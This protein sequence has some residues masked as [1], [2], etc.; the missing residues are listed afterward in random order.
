MSKQER[1]LTCRYW[2]EGPGGALILEFWAV[3]PPSTKRRAQRRVDGVVIEGGPHRKIAGR[4]D[5]ARIDLAGQDL[6]VIQTKRGKLGMN[7]LGQALFSRELMRAFTPR[8]VRSVAICNHGDEELE[9]IADGFG[10]EVVCF[11][12]DETREHRGS[13]DEPLCASVVPKT[14]SPR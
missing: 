10:I 13:G 3:R 5:R 12:E 1:E 4:R 7:L 2:R 6:V 9:E 8:S 14:A 11:E